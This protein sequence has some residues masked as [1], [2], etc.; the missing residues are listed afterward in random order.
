M[1]SLKQVVPQAKPG[2]PKCQVVG[3]CS[4]SSINVPVT[5]LPTYLLCIFVSVCL[6]IGDQDVYKLSLEAD[7]NQLFNFVLS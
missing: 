5:Y 4:L 6:S 3:T 2:L 1:L 7:C